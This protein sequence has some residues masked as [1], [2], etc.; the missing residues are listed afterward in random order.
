MKLSREVVVIELKNGTVVKG[1]ITGVDIAM[2]THLKDV[3]LTVKG[4]LPVK[5]EHLTIRGNN[6]RYYILPDAIPIDTLLIDEATKNKPQ[7][8]KNPKPKAK[9]AP[10][11]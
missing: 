10:R 1:T 2:N 8:D 5:L 6:I 7:K 4:R 11:R 9:A 3:T